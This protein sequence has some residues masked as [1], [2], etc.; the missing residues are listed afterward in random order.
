MTEIELY[1]RY[2]EPIYLP[3]MGEVIL[4]EPKDKR[5]IFLKE[6]HKVVA[7]MDDHLI[8]LLL[9]NSNW[10]FSLVGAW[11]CFAKNKIEF[12]DEI[13]KMLLQRKGGTVGY[14][15]S[16]AKFGNP[17]AIFYLR[18]YLEEELN[19][20]DESFQDT[21]LYS[22]KYIDKTKD[23][24]YATAILTSNGLW[25][26]FVNYE[27]GVT[28]FKLSL[29]DRWNNIDKHFHQYVKMF[30]FISKSLDGM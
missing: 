1:Q 20:K 15:Y 21:A 28:K 13:G 24:N 11:M 22:L 27:Y 12:T 5:E 25:D 23:K 4:T 16:L 2:V 26:K 3:L 7:E 30:D 18:Q 6:F 29:G 14:C 9:R 17:A 8:K 10:R 19:R